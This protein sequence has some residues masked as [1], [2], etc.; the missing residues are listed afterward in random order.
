MATKIYHEGNYTLDH[1]LRGHGDSSCLLRDDVI[2]K[3]AEF[4]YVFVQSVAW[5]TNLK[6]HLNSSTSPREWVQKMTP[7][8]YY[9][10]ISALL[11]RLSSQTKTFFVLGQVG[12]S[13]KNKTE[14]EPYVIENISDQYGWDMAP[15]L[16]DTALAVIKE[17]ELNIQI[18]D[19]REPLMQSVHAHPS[20][21][22]RPD[23]LHFCMNSSAINIYLDIYWNE[24]FQYQ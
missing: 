20:H 3:L 2:D 8:M 6:K 14:P 23:C 17:N 22:P 12:T 19:A 24:V 18:V 7:I 13:C 4:D 11:S 10:A 1:S 5:W 21:H 15:K 16:W 9:D